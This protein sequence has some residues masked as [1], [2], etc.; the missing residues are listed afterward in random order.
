MAKMMVLPR[1]RVWSS[2]SF[3][4]RRLVLALP[5][6]CFGFGVGL[7]GCGFNSTSPAALAAARKSHAKWIKK[8]PKISLMRRQVSE[9]SDGASSWDNI[10][11]TSG[12]GNARRSWYGNA[13][14]GYTKLDPRMLRAMKI[15]AKQGYQFRVTSIA[16]GSHSRGSRHYAGLAFDVDQ[17][18]GIKVGYGNPY[19]REF[20]KRCRELGATETLGPGDSG[21]SRHVHAAWPR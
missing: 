21:H 9:R 19:W 18:N 8:C 13:P 12:G 2:S 1:V 11:A 5:L 10:V 20:L 3:M 15:L 16:G 4:N 14:G 6:L 17:I 7:V